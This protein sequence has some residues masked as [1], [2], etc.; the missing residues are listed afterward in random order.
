MRSATLSPERPVKLQQVGCREDGRVS[1]QSYMISRHIINLAARSRKQSVSSDSRDNFRQVYHH[2]A[3]VYPSLVS[4]PW[5]PSWLRKGSTFLPVGSDPFTATSRCLSV[6]P[7]L[8]T[9]HGAPETGGRKAS[10]LPACVSIFALQLAGCYVIPCNP[11]KQVL[12]MLSLN[13]LYFFF[14][15]WFM[16]GSSCTLY[17]WQRNLLT[18]LLLSL[19]LSRS[20]KRI[21]VFWAFS[22]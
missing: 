12:K 7:D 22:G 18:F 5:L 17:P 8:H 11:L 15:I 16:N 19:N 4:R 2:T 21:P 20:C 9:F 1:T 14:G 10:W 13:V 3:T 6:P